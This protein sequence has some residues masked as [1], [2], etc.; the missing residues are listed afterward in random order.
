MDAGIVLAWSGSDSGAGKEPSQ[1]CQA[2]ERGRAAGM[3][4]RPTLIDF[5]SFDAAPRESSRR[6]PSQ[7][8]RRHPQQQQQHLRQ[9]NRHYEQIL[10]TPKANVLACCTKYPPPYLTRGR[11]SGVQ[12]RNPQSPNGNSRGDAGLRDNEVRAA[13][14]RNVNEG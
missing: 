14:N 3:P 2:R 13:P 11:S 4:P 8:A 5:N 10:L 9:L 7:H 12:Q 1:A 6:A